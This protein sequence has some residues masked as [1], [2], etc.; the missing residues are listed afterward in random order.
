MY[1]NTSGGGQGGFD[2]YDLWQVVSLVGTGISVIALLSGG[3]QGKQLGQLGTALGV[4]ST[5][6][7]W[8]STPPRCGRCQRRMSRPQ[9]D[10]QGGPQW[11]C[12]CGNALYPAN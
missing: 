2:W 1:G 9:P 6:A 7:Q 11:V 12:A 4:G 10:Y 3:K 5:A 8:K